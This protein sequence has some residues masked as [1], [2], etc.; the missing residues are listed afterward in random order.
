L[1][2]F[3]LLEFGGDELLFFENRYN[4]PID[5]LTYPIFG[6][7]VVTIRHMLGAAG[8]GKLPEFEQN[9]GVRLT[10]FLARVDWTIDPASGEDEVSLGVAFSAR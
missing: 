10:F 4:I 7:P 6:R 8:P 9:L 2:T 5:R 3:D 1:P